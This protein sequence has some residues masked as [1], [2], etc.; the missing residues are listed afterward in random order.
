[1]GFANHRELGT[2]A[3]QGQVRQAVV[4]EMGPGEIKVQQRVS[5]SF[6]C[7]S[8][9]FNLAP[10]A[11]QGGEDTMQAGRQQKKRLASEGAVGL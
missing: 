1:M 10:A 7:N 6:C 11:S 9:L 5:W 2:P 3:L 4:Q 8:G